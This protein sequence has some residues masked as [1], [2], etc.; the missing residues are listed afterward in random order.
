MTRSAEYFEK[1]PFG[2]FRLQ[3]TADGPDGPHYDL[4][5][6]ARPVAE[7]ST[8]YQID[9]TVDAV[10]VGNRE[11]IPGVD[12]DVGKPKLKSFHGK[13]SFQAGAGKWLCLFDSDQSTADYQLIIVLRATPEQS[14]K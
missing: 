9:C 5:L 8:D 1:M 13:L 4:K 6:S 11:R 12:L 2:V 10:V 14:E 7:H 3:H